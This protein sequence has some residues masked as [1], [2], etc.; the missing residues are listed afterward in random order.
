[1]GAG[2]SGLSCAITLENNGITPDIYEKRS[3]VGDRFV[4]GEIFMSVLTRPVN[5]VIFYLAKKHNIYL[6]PAANIKKLI[7]HSK[8]ETA[9]I[10]NQLG[11][12]TIRGRHQNSLEKQLAEQTNCKIYFNSSKSYNQLLHNY[13]HIIMAT[14]DAAYTEKLQD[15]RKDLSVTLKG[16]TISGNFNPYTV[17][18]WLNYDLAPGG[19]GYF[20]PFSKKEANIVIGIPES[21]VNNKPDLNKLWKNFYTEVCRKFKQNLKTTDQFQIRNYII[22][23]CSFPRIGNTYFTGNCLGTVMPFL[24][25][26]QFGAILSGIYAALDISGQG[27]YK[28]LINPLVN[29]YRNSLALRKTLQKLNNSRLNT[30]VKILA[31]FPE[32]LIFYNKHINFLKLLSYILRPWV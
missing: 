9:T 21:P 32:K 27:D 7:I 14:G 12:I 24:G 31:H 25:F 29:S 4:N 17:R 16:A 5:D 11:F 19:Y 3:M 22:G 30:I 10:K 8:N 20:I 15:Y 28:K 13:T 26:G 2:L 23:L 6:K 18:A 1:M